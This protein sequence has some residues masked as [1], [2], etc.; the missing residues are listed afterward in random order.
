MPITMDEV[1]AFI[2]RLPNATAVAKVQEASARRISELDMASF[3]GLTDGCQARINGRLRPTFLRH[4]SGT[5]LGRNRT[6]RRAAFLLDEESTQILRADSRNN[7][8][9]APED[10]TRFRIPDSLPVACLVP[11]GDPA[12]Q[13]HLPPRPARPGQERPS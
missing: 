12:G 4:L 6:G 8:Y 3:A 5:V 13:P 7:R 9:R 11:I 10:T 2:G 1:L